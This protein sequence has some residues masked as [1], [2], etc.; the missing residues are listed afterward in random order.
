MKRSLLPM[1][2]CPR[3]KAGLELHARAEEGGE[4]AEGDLTCDGCQASYPIRGG[5]PRFVGSGAYADSFGFQWD[6]FRLVQLDSRNGTRDSERTLA[7]TT[8]WSDGDYRGR[9]VLDAGVGAGRFAEVAAKKGAQVI[10]IDLT[11]AVEAAQANLAHFP[12]AHLVQADIFAMPFRDRTFDLAYSIGVLHHTPDVEGAFRKVAAAVKPGGALAV[13][14]YSAYGV[15][16]HS[17]DALRVLTTRLPVRLMFALSAAAVP[18]YFL[19]RAPV[20]G[21][22][23]A[24]LAPISLNPDWRWRWLDTFDWYTPRYQWKL[25]Y[26][27]VLRW[28]RENGFNDI[29]TSDEPIRMSGWKTGPVLRTGGA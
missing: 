18:L 20:L 25:R 9:L 26:P 11:R 2:A 8:G 27:E 13:Y 23:L 19:Y 29:H 17:S 6:R 14:L 3:C 4:V 22:A 1:L 12:G 28:F 10:G 24:K 15:E 5:I 7:E 16:R 21:P